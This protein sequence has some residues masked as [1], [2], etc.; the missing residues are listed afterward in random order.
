MSHASEPRRRSFS[1]RG[2]GE[3]DTAARARIFQALGWAIFPAF[4]MG[5]MVTVA[6]D[7]Q[8]GLKWTGIIMVVAGGG[9]LL[10]SEIMGRTTAQILHPGSTA[11]G[12]EYSG[13]AA[14]VARGRYQDAV[15]AYQ[16]AASEYPDDYIPCLKLAALL[17]ERVG[18]AEQSL[19]WYREARR[20]GIHPAEERAVM[21]Q[22]VEAAERGGNGLAAAPDLARY[23]EERAGTDEEAW[24]RRTLVELKRALRDSPESEDRS[25]TGD[26]AGEAWPASPMMGDGDPA[27][28]GDEPPLGPGPAL[29]F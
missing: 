11:R 6:A 3:K 19:R 16:E 8:T 24:A 17:S 2:P 14:L 29:G 4:I 1:S 12:R 10:F 13:V 27:D 20:R 18:D 15:L 23:A 22:M 5:L 25:G 26:G 28:D 9:S 21:R 7:L